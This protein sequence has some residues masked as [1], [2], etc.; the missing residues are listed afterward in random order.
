MAH[1]QFDEVLAAQVLAGAPN[2][3]AYLDAGLDIV[4]CSDAAA[5]SLGSSRD[6]VIGRSLVEL[7][8]PGTRMTDTLVETVR[9]GKQ[10]TLVFTT[11]GTGGDDDERTFAG[12]FMPDVDEDGN[13]RGVYANA[14]DVT[15][16]IVELRMA[17]RLAES[18][19]VILQAIASKSD[20]IDLLDVLAEE[21]LKAVNGV[22]SLV[23]VRSGGVW[24]VTHHHG[25]GGELRV[26]I[27]YPLPER[28]VIQ[29]AADTGRIQF[30][31]DAMAHPRTNKSIMARFGVKS[32]VAVP[33]TL[34]G[35]TLGV[36]EIV[37]TRALQR[38][39]DTTKAYFNTLASAA[40]LA[41]GRMLEFQ[42]ERRIADTLQAAMLRLPVEVQG[43]RFASRYAAAW[44]EALV[45]GDFFD[46]FEIE[47]TKVGIT[48]GDVS[49]KGLD[50]AIVTS[51]VRDSLRL[52]A[53]DGLRPAACVTKTN[54]LL[55]QVTPSDMFAT[56][57]FGILD[58]AS[59]ELAYVTAAH[60]PAILQHAAGGCELLEG[61]GSVVGAFPASEFTERTT[62]LEPGDALVMYTDGL[63][64][65]RRDGEM[66]SVER[67]VECLGI[68]LGGS[69]E[70]LVNDVFADVRQYTDCRLHDDLAMLA[71]S[72]DAPGPPAPSA[73]S[74]VA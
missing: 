68:R 51:R 44:E 41:Y 52:C 45:G 8:G 21:C 20:P 16:Q 30:V 22:H 63:T 36:F 18:L 42:H 69:L 64:E 73:G 72:L 38:F 13:V 70:A 2:F 6:E 12:S 29:D 3:I 48:I 34:R 35:E 26:G 5:R 65:A 57:I 37:F 47:G 17:A 46:V 59:G 32:F 27:E 10:H 55:Y 7:R 15:D 1:V 9:T 67:V 19:N 66:Y 24:T 11:A 14:L 25:V 56:L 49:G 71:I 74:D 58:T 62:R 53:L 60:P 31:E 43:I 50:A 4:A 61:T 28:P 39:D 33:L 40:S 54:R 23:S